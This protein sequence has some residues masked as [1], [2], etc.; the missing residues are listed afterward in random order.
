MR[1][2]SVTAAALGVT[3]LVSGAHGA[4]AAASTTT[5]TTKTTTQQTK[6]VVHTLANL[7]PVKI[8]AKSTV[9]LTDVNILNLDEESILTYTLTVKNGDNKTLDL[10]DYWSKV[11]T[12]SGT[13]Y[14]TSLMTKDKEKK[15]LSAGS[16]TT[17]TYVAKVGKNIKISSLLF[18][19]I[20][21]DFSQA[22]YE[23][24][25]G[26]FKV[27]ASYITSTPADQ[28]KT[29]RV[30][31]TPVKTMINQVAAYTSGIIITLV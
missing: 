30:F 7:N 16:S 18:Q 15:K 17:L 27:P 13:T 5:K 10:L 31:D 11:K 24:L 1:K 4:L 2:V 19:V 20:K 23:S 8:S 14:S 3:L 21:W 29:L 25:K 28:S 6:P 12:T 9:R 26:Q 22:N